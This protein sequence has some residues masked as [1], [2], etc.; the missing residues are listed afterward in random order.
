MTQ[1]LFFCN[2]KTAKQ[3]T[4]PEKGFFHYNYIVRLHVSLK[5]LSNATTYIKFKDVDTY[6]Q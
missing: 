2:Y 6:K 5:D 1:Q 3:K 4:S